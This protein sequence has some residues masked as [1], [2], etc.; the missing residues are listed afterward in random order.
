M[1][2]TGPSNPRPFPRLPQKV[3]GPVEKI[4][5]RGRLGMDH[6]GAHQAV[7][8]FAGHGQ[9]FGQPFVADHAE[10]LGRVLRTGQDVHNAGRAQSGIGA[11]ELEPRRAAAR[12]AIVAE[13]LLIDAVGP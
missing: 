4:S 3:I 1:R 13:H 12:R 9:S 11:I 6:A 8:G 10:A 2:D 7:W 5:P